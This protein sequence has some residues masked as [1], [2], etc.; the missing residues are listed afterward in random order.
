MRIASYRDKK[1]TD[2]ENLEQPSVRTF[3]KQQ[4]TYDQKLAKEQREYQ[5]SLSKQEA[6]EK[7]RRFL[8]L[9][10]LDSLATDDAFE[11]T[12]RKQEPV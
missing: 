12:Q 11:G 10:N 9:S 6:A 3:L 5:E 8:A 1:K 7:V 4:G 2:V